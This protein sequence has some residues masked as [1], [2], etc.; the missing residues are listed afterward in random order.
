MSAESNKTIARRFYDELINAADVSRG[1][2]LVAPAFVDHPGVQGLP[3]GR[4]GLLQFVSLAHTAFPDLHV[5]IEDLMGEGDRVAVR[6]T[7]SG[8]QRG[9]FMG[10]I[11]P[12][13]KRVT[14][15][16]IDILRIANGRIVERWNQRDLLGLME[17]LGAV[18]RRGSTA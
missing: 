11:P 8:T 13:G 16:G 14:W 1:D 3:P 15:T 10:T 9:V 7:V 17:Q 4:E 6:V 12:T 2:E 18:T 5:A